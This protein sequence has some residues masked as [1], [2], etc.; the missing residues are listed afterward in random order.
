MDF[1]INQFGMDKLIFGSD[2][3]VCLLAA[4]Y[5]QVLGLYD[6]YFQNF[7]YEEQKKIYCDNA[8]K[9]YSLEVA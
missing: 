9:A 5:S 2:W 6:Y 1:V 4:E 3:P 7:S 8:V